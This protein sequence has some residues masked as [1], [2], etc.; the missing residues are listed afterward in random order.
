[1]IFIYLNKNLNQKNQM[2]QTF[3]KKIQ[4]LKKG[5]PFWFLTFSENNSYFNFINV[6]RHQK[7]NNLVTVVHKHHIIPKYLLKQTNH[8]KSFCNS[9]QNTIL[10]SIADH[11]KA[12]QLFYQNYPDVRN[13]GAIYLLNG[14][15]SDS[16][17][18]WQQAGAYASH[19]KQLEI[20]GFLFSKQH[21]KKTAICSLARP[22]AIAIR[23]QG[24]KKGGRK[25]Q[26]N[27]IIKKTD[28]YLW[29]FKKKEVFC[30]FNCLTGG[31]VL[32]QLQLY[33]KTNIKRVS[34]LITKNRLSAYNW[35]C[36][37]F[38]DFQAW[39][40]ISSETSTFDLKSQRGLT[41]RD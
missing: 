3:S 29:L 41:F 1:M 23:R 13:K 7:I 33:K 32:E 37:K 38:Y 5:N 36:I 24:G 16:L 27:R 20:R 31:D 30:I 18:S 14:S 25:T 35:S 15:M 21:Q 12:H 6:C 39:K 17:R 19:R 10:L 11:K 9:K 2:T 40:E 22:D 28:K 4:Q 34:P 26:E 8:E